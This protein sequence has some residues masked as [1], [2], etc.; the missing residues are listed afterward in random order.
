MTILIGLMLAQSD[1]ANRLSA[2]AVDVDL[3]DADFDVAIQFF[4]ELTGVNMVVSPEAA[5]K[6]KASSVTL[7]AKGV[8]AQTAIKLV[9]AQYDLVAQVKD[10]IVEITTREALVGN[11][12]T[13][14]YDIRDIFIKIRQFTG[15]RLE[16]IS[17]S[18]GNQP[19]VNIDE[20]VTPLRLD[21]DSTLDLIRE[22]CAP[23]S[24][25]NTQASLAYSTNGMLIVTNTAAAHR[26]ISRFIDMMR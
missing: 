23:R 2:M 11:V 15:P 9:L 18:A 10:G 26:E 19:G 24:W 4:R 16:L 8:R 22:T 3:R 25:D 21:E 13:R 20:P 14:V 6:G 17:A 1:V 7:K 5:G 12:V